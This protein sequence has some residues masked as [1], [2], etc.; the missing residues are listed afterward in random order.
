MSASLA[1]WVSKLG[2]RLLL[3]ST[4]PDPAELPIDRLCSVEKPHPNG[5][6][7]LLS[8]R[9]RA[10]ARRFDGG[11][12]IVRAPF[13]D[14]RCAQWI[15]EDPEAVW[16]GL[17][18]ALV[19]VPELGFDGQSPHATIDP[20]A[21]V[22]ATAL[23]AAGV[24]IGPFVTIDAGTVLHPN[25]AVY[26]HSSVGPDCVLGAGAVVG[27]HCRL[28]ARVHLGPNAVVGDQGFG[29]DLQSRA[30]VRHVG[31]V[32]LGD[33]VHLGACTCVDA[34]TLDPTIV[35]AG[36]KLDN[37]VHLAHNVQVG[38]NGWILAQSGVAGSSKLGNG[39]VLAGQVGVAGHITIGDHTQVAAKSG[40]AHSVGEGQ[41]IAGTPAYELVRWR[42][43]STLL[44]DLERTHA[45]LDALE[46]QLARKSSPPDDD[47]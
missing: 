39:V 30:R 26:A 45:R 4:S 29:Y 27:P 20:T 2:G 46:A 12:L 41:A 17:L 43:V 42:R 25:V 10:A 3:A 23:I 13:G 19:T 16:S 7:A 8:P 5:V 32:I 33:D 11:A 9:Y 31:G 28:G 18:D 14:A 22:D 37:L 34:G 6:A 15:V 35:A 1:E 47:A 40:V 38:E 44:K 24:F 36:T 21:R